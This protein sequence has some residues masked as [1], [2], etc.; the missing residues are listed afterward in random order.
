MKKYVFLAVTA[1]LFVI[2]LQG[3]NLFLQHKNFVLKQQEFMTK[4][5]TVSIDQEYSIRAH[6][7]YNPFKN[8]KQRF[9]FKQ[10]SEKEVMRHK[11][12]PDDIINLQ[13]VNVQD[14]RE[15]G[16]VEKE[17]DVLSLINKD[18]MERKGRHLDFHKLDS[19]FIKN[20]GEEMPHTY[21]ILDE[22]KKVVKSYG[23]T[24]QISDWQT[25]K[26]VAIGLKPVRFIRVVV[27]VPVSSFV[28]TSIWTLIATVFLAI[29]IVIC[30]TVQ[31]VVIR[32]KSELLESREMSI[33]G[34]IHDLK[35]PLASVLFILSYLQ[36]K[37]DD[38]NL[39]GLIK[40]AEVQVSRLS[41]T[42]KGILLTAK[43][44]EKKL[45]LDKNP[46]DVMELAGFAKDC[47][48][49]NYA[50]K[51]HQ[52]KLCDYRSDRML[53]LADKVLI[54]NV[55]RN[56]LEN[57]VKYAD[58]GVCVNVGVYNDDKNIIVKV[59]DN[60]YGIEKKYQKQI[61]KQFF[62]VPTSHPK[63]GYGIGLALVK[64]VVESHG[65][66]VKVESELG[67]GSCFTFTLPLS[68]SKNQ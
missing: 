53:V 65:G 8:G 66:K 39:L 63:S 3:Y 43:G 11:P 19:I 68:F 16:L 47:V 2:F 59:E 29:F 35:A 12:S 42:I 62:R 54:E 67:K 44:C 40:K 4:V 9:L 32:R 61:F 18:R 48:D 22:N 15:R 27:D 51:Q 30:I 1:I 37:I 33:H 60:G 36:G 46:I 52:I 7:S 64:Y 28:K 34:T 26:D 25:S 24:G 58:E 20:L 23:A 50:D 41:E 45:S 14:L 49:I 55:M 21:L 10:V 57:A 5:L 38:E 13:E 56:L 17:A 6:K 31:F